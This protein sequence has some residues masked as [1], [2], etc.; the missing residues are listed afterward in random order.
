MWFWTFLL[1]HFIGYVE[2]ICKLSSV[3]GLNLFMFLGLHMQTLLYVWMTRI[4]YENVTIRMN[5][6][7]YIWKRYYTYEWLGL[8][9]KTLLYVW[10]NVIWPTFV[11]YKELGF[12]Q[13]IMSGFGLN[14]WPAVWSNWWIFTKRVTNVVLLTPLLYL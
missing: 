14:Y 6:S 1:P 2:V 4:T 7:D 13:C 11:F 8:H 9:M 12:L 5:D 3:L 10:M